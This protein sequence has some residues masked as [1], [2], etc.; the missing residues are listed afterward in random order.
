MQS[1][2]KVPSEGGNEPGGPAVMRSGPMLASYVMAL[3]ALGGIATGLALYGMRGII[4]SVFLALFAAVGFDPLV[5]W[6]QRHRMSRPLAILTVIL[7]IVA[8]LV[9]ILWV[10][11]PLVFRQIQTLATAI[12]GE[13]EHLKAQG[14]FDPANATSNGALGGLA[15]WVATEIKDPAVWASLGSGI[16]GFG[17]SVVNG[18]ASGF[19]MAILTIYFIAT[20]DAT[21][22]AAYNLISASHRPAFIGYSE[23]ILKNF[24]RYLSGMVILA[25]FNAVFS[26]VLLVLTGVPGAFLIGVLAFFITLIPLIGTILT[27]V[28]MTILAFFHAP[29]SGLVVLIFMLIYMQVEAYVLT[30]KVMGKAVQVPGSVVLISA[31][32]GSTLFGLPGALVA[33]PISAGIILIIKEVVM[34]RKQLT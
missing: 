23:R 29:V 11:L 30:P 31:L 7:I 21:K 17:V 3:G 4:Y 2:K 12:P 20:Y 22:Q 34:P 19:F 32:A 18:V 28:A 6:F 10:V 5:R 25:F 1:A 13:I 33:I 26:V 9:T 15:N 14:W 24:G 27:T 8:I 16:A